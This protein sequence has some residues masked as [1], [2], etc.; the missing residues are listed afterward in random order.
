MAAERTHTKSWGDITVRFEVSIEGD[1]S[2]FFDPLPEASLDAANFEEL[3]N[4]YR[5]HVID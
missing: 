2:V 4:F 5:S 3:Y 1:V